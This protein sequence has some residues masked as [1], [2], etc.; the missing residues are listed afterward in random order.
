MK[1]SE[2]KTVYDLFNNF[3]PQVGAPTDGCV[4]CVV[5]NGDAV[6]KILKNHARWLKKQQTNSLRDLINANH[7]LRDEYSRK[8]RH[9]GRSAWGC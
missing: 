7:R 8:L 1:I 4:E 9:E 6:E 3:K 5:E 2:A